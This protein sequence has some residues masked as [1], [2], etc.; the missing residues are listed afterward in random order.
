MLRYMVQAFQDPLF[1][2][3]NLKVP[4]HQ[5]RSAPESGMVNYVFDE[6]PQMVSRVLNFISLFLN[7]NLNCPMHHVAKY[8]WICSL[9]A[10][11][12]AMLQ[13]VLYCISNKKPFQF[14]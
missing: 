1:I 3:F 10:N 14:M 13:P 9:F 8:N 11:P 5:I 7:Q 2:E 12:H 6:G 4:S